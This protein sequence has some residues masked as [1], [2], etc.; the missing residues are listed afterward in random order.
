[1]SGNPPRP[2]LFPFGVRLEVEVESLTVLLGAVPEV[3]LRAV[4]AAT[5]EGLGELSSSATATDGVEV[6]AVEAVELK[7]TAPREA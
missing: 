6:G 7:E 4:L 3:S 1:M 2:A 5:E